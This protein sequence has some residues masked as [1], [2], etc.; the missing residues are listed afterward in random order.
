MIRFSISADF[1]ATHRIRVD[2]RGTLEPL[3]A[4]N[5]RVRA[6]LCADDDGGGAMNRAIETLAAWVARHEGNCFNDVPPFD[7]INPTAEEV[8]RS[9]ASLLDD[10]V[11]GARVERLEVGEAAG[12]SATYWP[13]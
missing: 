9:L 10:V 4:H 6:W 12:F 7:E 11:S 1:P 3:H 2:W 8:A 5:W 13:P